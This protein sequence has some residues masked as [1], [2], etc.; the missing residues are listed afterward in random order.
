M[1]G[2]RDFTAVVTRS[3]ARAAEQAGIELLTVDNHNDAKLTLRNASHLIKESVHLAIEFQGNESIAPVISEKFLS[4]AIPLIAV[5]VPHPGAIYF[6][7]NNYAAG[8]MAGQHMGR[9]VRENW[10]GEMDALWLIAYP[11][12]GSVP[13]SRLTGMISGLHECLPRTE[14]VPVFERDA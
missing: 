8:L 12:A 13:H 14:R 10:G 5:D 1:A 9:W 11:R 6:G 2:T 7:A 4:A 3:L